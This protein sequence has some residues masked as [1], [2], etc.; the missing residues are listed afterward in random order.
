MRFL[1]LNIFLLLGSDEKLNDGKKTDNI[2]ASTE[3]GVDDAL[4]Y[5]CNWLDYSKQI[6][7]YIDRRAI[8]GKWQYLSMMLCL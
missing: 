5:A 3:K 7:Q 4:Q 8:L 6:S 2:L 1:T